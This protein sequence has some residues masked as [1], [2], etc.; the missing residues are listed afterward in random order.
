VYL[1]VASDNP[2]AH[3]FYLR[4]GFVLDGAEQVVPFLGEEIHEVRFVR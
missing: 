2:R 1:W 3:R 4:N